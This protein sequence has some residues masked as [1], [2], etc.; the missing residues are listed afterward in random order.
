MNMKNLLTVLFFVFLSL[1][2]NAQDIED[3]TYGTNNSLEVISW[4]IEFFPLNDDVTVNYLSQIIQALDADIIAFQ[5]VAD[6]A[7]FS[8]MI[9]E[10]DGYDSHVGTTD[11]LIKL[12][13]AYKTDAIQPSNI[14]EIYTDSEYY[15]PF[16]RRPLVMEFT[17]NNEDFI[18]INN[19]FKAMGDGTLDLNDPND[20]ENRRYVATNLI[21]DY[22]DNNFPNERVFVVGDLNDVVTDD[23]DNN[24]FQSI[25]DDPQNFLF[26]DYSIATGSQD[27]WSYP[28]YPSHID[29]II[30]TNELFNQFF[31]Q[32]SG[33]ETLKIEDYLNG[34]WNDYTQ[35]ISDHRPLAIKLFMDENTVFNKDFED[36]NLTS[37][38]WNSYSI[39]GEQNWTVPSTQYGHNNSYCAFMSGYDNGSHENENWLVSPS[40]NPDAYNHLRFS[41]WN[42]SAY[43]GPPLQLFYSTNFSGDPQ[44]ATWV[45][46]DNVIWHNGETNWEWTFSGV[47]DLAHLSGQTA[48]IAFKYTSTNEQSASWEIDD[49]LLSDAPNTCFISAGISP[50]NSGAVAGTGMY[51]Y[52]ETVKLI[53]TNG[54]DYSF[55]NWT[56]NGTE[57]STNPEYSFLATTDKVFVANFANP[58]D[59]TNL[60]ND[61]KITVFPNPSEGTVFVDGGTIQTIEI[62]NVFGGLIKR[63]NVTSNRTIINLENYDK[64]IYIFK[65]ISDNNIITTKVLLN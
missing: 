13:Y 24:V 46:I 8:E 9:G 61:S 7:V 44:T 12:A 28:N 10:I 1:L 27:N 38:G 51:T 43:T 17:Y 11:N 42:T 18:V 60:S 19:H 65:M 39:T 6:V 55:V 45:E 36:Q 23:Y 37:G 53:A 35:N 41:F 15:L 2:A 25:L 49:I 31:T 20:E 26:A 59:V 47:I 52:G 40:F 62:F 50:A 58:L 16:L 34:G 64:G 32:T 4:N 56:E 33:I 30:I 22:I 57:V 5:E 63:I 14:Y 29:H 48:H 3:L 21:K 54:T